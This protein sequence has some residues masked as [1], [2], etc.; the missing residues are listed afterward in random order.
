MVFLWAIAAVP[1][2]TYAIVQVSTFRTTHVLL[3]K[4]WRDILTSKSNSIRPSRSS[5]SFSARCHSY[6]GFRSSCTESKNPPSSHPCFV[7][8][9]DLCSGWSWFK[10]SIYGITTAAIFGGAQA[11]LILTL[12]VCLFFPPSPVSPNVLGEF[13]GLESLWSPSPFPFPTFIDLFQTHAQ[14]SP[15]LLPK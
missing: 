5:L 15:Q 14:A 13:E 3:S 10:A 1:F 6:H 11:V 4:P 9:T 2:G 8:L 7:D 12:R